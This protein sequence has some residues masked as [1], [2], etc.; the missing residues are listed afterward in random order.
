MMRNIMIVSVLLL[1]MTH[2]ARA[3][4]IDECLRNF[5]DVDGVRAL[6]TAK[7]VA[8]LDAIR[9]KGDSR[10]SV[11]CPRSKLHKDR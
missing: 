9:A 11:T 2:D 3:V 7:T 5:V 8:S 4:G 1:A 10:S 6:V